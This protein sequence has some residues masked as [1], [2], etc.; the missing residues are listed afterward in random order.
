MYRIVIIRHPEK[1]PRA[2]NRCEMLKTS[3]V[4]KIHHERKDPL[5]VDVL[6]KGAIAAADREIRVS[7]QGVQDVSVMIRSFGTTCFWRVHQKMGPHPRAYVLMRAF[8]LSDILINEHRDF[9]TESGTSARQH[10]EP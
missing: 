4:N 5:I 9:E 3:V 2:L 10:F 1:E 7:K 6:V 8:Y